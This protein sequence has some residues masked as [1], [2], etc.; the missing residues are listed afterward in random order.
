MRRIDELH[1]EYPFAEAGCCAT[2]ESRGGFRSAAVTWRRWMKRDEHRGALSQARTRRSRRRPQDY[3]YLL[4][5]VKVEKPKPSLG[6]RHH[7]Y[8]MARGLFISSPLSTGSRGACCPIACRSR[9]G[10]F[11]CRGV[12]EALAKHGKPEI[13]NTDQGSQFTSES[14]RVC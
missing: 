4:R 7:V 14:S 12:E 8:S 10:R 6:D 9:W 1:L 5:G 3:P 2:S 11:L 13:F